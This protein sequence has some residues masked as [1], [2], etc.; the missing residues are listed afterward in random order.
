M[1]RLPTK[2]KSQNRD[3]LKF[4]KKVLKYMPSATG[5]NQDTQLYPVYVGQDGDHGSSDNS[6]TSKYG[7]IKVITSLEKH[8]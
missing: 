2:D 6:I 8:A 5:T 4:E 3:I 7:S 1:L